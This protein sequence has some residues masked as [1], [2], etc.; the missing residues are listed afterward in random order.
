MFFLSGGDFAVNSPAT[1][2]FALARLS[3][4]T[5]CLKTSVSFTPVIRARISVVP[6]GCAGVMKRIGRSGYSPAKIAPAAKSTVAPRIKRNAAILICKASCL[7]NARCWLLSFMLRALKDARKSHKRQA[8]LRPPYA[9][10]STGSVAS[11]NG[12]K[13]ERDADPTHSTRSGNALRRG[14]LHRSVAQ[15]RYDTAAAWQ[16]RE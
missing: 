9:R 16:C 10:A 14:R 5:C 4:I 1:T 8:A 2:P 11:Y 3:T 13:E 6:P 7:R 12:G 15:A